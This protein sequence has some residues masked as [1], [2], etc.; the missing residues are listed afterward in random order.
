V[1]GD[2]V[3]LRAYYAARAAE[4]DRVYEKPERRNALTALRDWLPPRVAG[5]RLLEVACGTGYWT[6]LVA[7]VAMRRLEDGSVHHVLKNFPTEAE[8]K[9][10]IA[11]IGDHPCVTLF[12]YYWA[13]EFRTVT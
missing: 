4:Y 12:E 9:T 13:F 1:T 6:Q 3:S 11:G 2:D 7:P 5:H 8:L 10:A